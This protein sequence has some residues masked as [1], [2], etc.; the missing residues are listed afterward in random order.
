MTFCSYT[1]LV[2]WI[3][4]FF[5]RLQWSFLLNSKF[6][7]KFSRKP[8]SGIEDQKAPP[9]P[10][11]KTSDL[12]W[13]KL[14]PEYP[15]KFSRKPL[16]GIEDQ[17]APPPMSENFRFGM[18]KVNSGITPPFRKTSDLVWPKLTLEYP[19]PSFRKTSDLG[20]PKLTPDIPPLVQTLLFGMTK[21]NCGIP[22]PHWK[23]SESLS[24]FRTPRVTTCG[25][26]IQPG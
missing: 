19:P 3:A 10:F 22:P 14:T 26:F 7:S 5:Q 11:Q 8:L 13:P 20:W 25:D 16:S 6:W 4:L 15:P 1:T 2:K 12:G 9:P 17:K 23:L 18:T 24:P 21:V